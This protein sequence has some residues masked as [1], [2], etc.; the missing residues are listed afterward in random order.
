MEHP[1]NRRHSITP[2]PVPI[3]VIDLVPTNLGLNYGNLASYQFA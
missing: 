1:S 3:I 2:D